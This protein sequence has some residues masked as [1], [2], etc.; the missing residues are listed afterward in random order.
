LRCTIIFIVLDDVEEEL[1]CAPTWRFC[2]ANKQQFHA[3]RC[4]LPLANK[5]IAWWEIVS[6]YRLAST[7][8]TCR[9]QAT[10]LQ[11]PDRVW[12]MWDD[13]CILLHS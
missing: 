3:N 5:F 10:I 6:W 8:L 4:Q 2:K 1:Y 12:R 9:S 13:Y 7:T 11:N